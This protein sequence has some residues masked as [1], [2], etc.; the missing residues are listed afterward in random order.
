MQDRVHFTQ[1][2]PTRKRMLVT[3]ASGFVGGALAKHLVDLGYEV[4]ALGRRVELENEVAQI[5]Q[6]KKAE[7]ADSV[8]CYKSV[9]L[10]DM[11][12]LSQAVGTKPIECIFHLASIGKQS[13]NFKDYI[14]NNIVPM[15]NVITLSE[16]VGCKNIIFSSTFDALS[17]TDGG[18]YDERAPVAHDNY[19]GLSKY[20]CE[21]LLKLACD[22]IKDL[23]CAA[24]R[25][26]GLVGKGQ[27]NGLAY[28]FSS[29]LMQNRTLRGV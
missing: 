5:L 21:Q 26:P 2:Q 6:D 9:D 25:F 17:L 14:D 3:G 15:M 23:F 10:Q 7:G 13:H 22:D 12:K 4:I 20:T 8:F 11:S 19:Y 27:N 28:T 1:E 24:L 18:L 16:Q 29:I